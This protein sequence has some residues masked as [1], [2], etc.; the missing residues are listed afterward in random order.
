MSN[1]FNAGNN[2]TFV[3]PSPGGAAAP[4]SGAAQ[5]VWQSHEPEIPSGN[6]PLIAVAN[7]ILNLVYQIRTLVHN[8]DPERLRNYLADEI[9]RFDANAKAQGVPAEHIV[10]ARYCLCTVLDEAAAQT[11][12]GGSGAWSKNS[13]LVTFHNETWGG[14]KFF[15]LLAKLAQSPSQHL[16]VLELMYYCIAL[17][18]EGRY[19]IVSNGQSQLENLKRRLA[20][21]IKNGRGVP[22]RA[23]SLHW[24]GHAA[25]LP[26]IWGMVPVWVSAILAVVLGVGVYMLLSF[27]L[28]ARSDKSFLAISALKLPSPPP[29]VRDAPPPLRFSKFL[30][31]EIREGLV[32]V[33]ENS[34][35]STVVIRGDGLFESGSATMRP[36]YR[37]IVDRIAAAINEVK[38][39]VLVS[40][41][42]DDRPIRSVRFPSNWELSKERARAVTA[43]L[44]TTVRTPGRITIE[45]RG[46]ADPVA[47]NTTPAGRAQNRRVEIT[48]FA[49]PAELN[50]EVR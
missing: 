38:G 21:I 17:G 10:A 8:A 47:D 19:R 11:P 43:Q 50:K 24:Q 22:D 3:M 44:E 23:L 35:Q 20:D 30:E 12:W 18:F 4:L 26:R 32:F 42:T 48:V 33:K 27:W 46:E 37:D 1:S 2:R 45:G 36:Q 49:S 15:Q 5:P 13:L 16:D 34:E 14:E 9:R 25:E 39:R 29:V 31:K 40:G 7:P 28:A 41:H 6:T